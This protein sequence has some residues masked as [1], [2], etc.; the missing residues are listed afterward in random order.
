MLSLR[1]AFKEVLTKVAVLQEMSGQESQLMK[2]GEA[3]VG[4]KVR[5]VVT[6]AAYPEIKVGTKATV[7]E[8]LSQKE[9]A[10]TDILLIHP[11]TWMN[12]KVMPCSAAQVEL[13]Y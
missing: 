2:P 3:K 6:F 8:V 11:H 1:S 9:D 13:V 10:E 5:T 4:Q 7:I 12:K